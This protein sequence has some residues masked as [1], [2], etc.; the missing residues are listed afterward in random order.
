[1]LCWLQRQ[2]LHQEVQVASRSVE[3]I[4]GRGAEQLKTPHVKALAELTQLFA[5]C[6]YLGV[7]GSTLQIRAGF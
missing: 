5:L 4:C 3:A 6:F 1:M 7:H 2:K